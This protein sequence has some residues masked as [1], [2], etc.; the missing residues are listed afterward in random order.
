MQSAPLAC[1]ARPPRS[2]AVKTKKNTYDTRCYDLLI[3][4]DLKCVGNLLRVS[5]L[6]KHSQQK[7]NLITAIVDQYEIILKSLHSSDIK[8]ILSTMGV[9]A[10]KMNSK[11]KLI[12]VAN[13]SKW[14]SRL[15]SREGALRLDYF[16]YFTEKDFF[17]FTSYPE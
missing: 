17:G 15:V 4:A 11:D 7:A 2:L 3:V 6:W 13:L 5:K 8:V 14:P 9:N 10:I 12:K 1:T 16:C